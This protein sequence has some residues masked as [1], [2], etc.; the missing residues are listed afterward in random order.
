MAPSKGVRLLAAIALA[1]TTGCSNKS[2]L[3]PIISQA[4]GGTRVISVPATVDFGNVPIGS[5]AT[6]DV[7]FA[8]TG[9][10]TLT[11]QSITVAGGT[12][13]TGFTSTFTS[14]ST[15][16]A[17]ASLPVTFAFA[18]TFPTTY[19]TTL[20]LVGNQTSGSNTINITGT[21]TI[22]HIPL[23]TRSGKGD[24]TFTLPSY[25]SQVR[26]TGHFVDTGGP[27]NFQ[28]VWSEILIVNLILRTADFDAV[29]NFPGGGP[30]QIVNSASIE[31]SF[32]EVR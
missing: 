28:V 12:G 20:T 19:S 3:D 24:T 29:V 6:R 18:P 2:P 16:A 23:F 32:T 30:V 27:S 10:S 15:I 31:W 21:G 1:A 4:T 25:V 26:V 8:N 11:V 9:N 13:T 22:D 5:T 17:G 14:N 7:T